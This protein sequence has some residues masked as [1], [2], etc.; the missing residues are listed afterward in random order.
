LNREGALVGDG[1]V[2][3][4]GHRATSQ[5]QGSGRADLQGLGAARTANGQGCHLGTGVERDV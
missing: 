5:D 3:P 4:V 1:P 2:G